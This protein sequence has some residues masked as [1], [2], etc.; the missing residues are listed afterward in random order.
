MLEEMIINSEEFYKEL[1]TPYRVVAIVSGAL[2]DAAATKY[3]LEACNEQAKQYVHLL[4]SPLTA[5]ERTLCCVLENYQTENG[6]EIPEPLRVYMG[7]QSSLP[8]HKNPSTKGR[9]K[10][11]KA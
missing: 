5:T 4:N 11:S 1:K 6:V 9:G 7:G 3:D 2:N 8:F 10:K